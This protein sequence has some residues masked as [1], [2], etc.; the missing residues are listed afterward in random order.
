MLRWSFSGLFSN[1]SMHSDNLSPELRSRGLQNAVAPKVERI[2][3]AGMTVGGPLRQDRLW[4]FGAFRHWGTKNPSIGLF[5]NA[6]QGGMFFEPDLQRPAFRDERYG[7]AQ[8]T[9]N[10][11]LPLPGDFMVSGKFQNLPGNSS[12][13]G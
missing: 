1:S 11:S 6:N 5:L 7:R 2:Y 12:T 8:F 3:D 4:F 13:S 9:I 10:G